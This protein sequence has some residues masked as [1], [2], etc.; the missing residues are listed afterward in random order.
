[1]NALAFER[2]QADGLVSLTRAV[3]TGRYAPRRSVC[4]IVSHPKTREVFAADFSDRI[5]HHLL[6]RELEPYWE[7]VF[8]ADS[9]ACREGKGTLAAVE[10]LGHFI[11][12]VT[13]NGAKRAHFLQ[14]DIRNFFMSID[15]NILF[16]LLDR[17]LLKQYGIPATRLS[18]DHPRREEY[19]Q[20][21]TLLKTLLYHD[22]TKNYVRKGETSEWDAIAPEKS[23][24]NCPSG[25]GLP[26]GNLTSQFFAN[27]YLNELDQFVKHTLKARHY[28]RYVDDFVLL[29]ENPA[30]LREWRTAIE[31]FLRER[32][33]LTLKE[34][35]TLKPVSCGVN[36]LGYVQHIHHRLVRRRVA[37]NFEQKLEGYRIREQASPLTYPEL[38]KLGAVVTSYLAHGSKANGYRLLTG[39]LGRHQWLKNYY[40]IV[41]WKATIRTELKNEHL[42]ETNKIF[43]E[44]TA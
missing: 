14:L 11:R 28:V 33:H 30:Q 32:L 8:I 13:G 42:I 43:R 9:Y 39:I 24:F 41:K 37:G 44:E 27:V 16:S 35:V 20:V 36:F 12:S 21:R 29:H 10:R 25:K 15:K 1:M 22:P 6:V 4:F 17:G 23:L 26:I 7:R 38:Q 40:R 5:V 19:E 18:F 34:P 3:R 31:K 2:D